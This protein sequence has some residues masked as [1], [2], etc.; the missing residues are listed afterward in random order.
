MTTQAERI[1]AR[2]TWTGL[3]AEQIA[4]ALVELGAGRK[5]VLPRVLAAIRAEQ[6]EEIEVRR[7]VIEHERAIESEWD[8]RA[9]AVGGYRQIWRTTASDAASGRRPRKGLCCRRRRG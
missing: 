8:D 7:I 2:L 5:Q 9:V 6:T 3:R 1:I 4:D